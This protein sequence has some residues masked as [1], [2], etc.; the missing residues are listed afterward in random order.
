MKQ[1]FNIS[2]VLILLLLVFFIAGCNDDSSKL[3]DLPEQEVVFPKDP[4]KF[5]KMII[6]Y[7]I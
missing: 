5:A 7:E 6:K 3:P 2:K 1:L 4:V